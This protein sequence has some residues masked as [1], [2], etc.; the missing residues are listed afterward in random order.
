M[1]PFCSRT[2][3][4]RTC[5]R[6]SS[7]RFTRFARFVLVF[8]SLSLFFIV[9]LS[10]SLCLSL[11]LSTS[12]SLS[13]YPSTRSVRSSTAGSD[14]ISLG[15]SSVHSSLLKWAAYY[16]HIIIY[17]DCGIINVVYIYN[18]LQYNRRVTITIIISSNT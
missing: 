12:P 18:I 9:S 1:I 8:F 7:I 4:M 10:H 13:V 2:Q 5:S 14:G 15:P 16:I 17:R 6:A 11:S 3:C